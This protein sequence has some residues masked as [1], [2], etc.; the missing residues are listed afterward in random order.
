M[1]G[2]QRI[3][4]MPTNYKTYTYVYILYT[5]R[6][7]SYVQNNKMHFPKCTS[8]RLVGTVSHHF[9]IISANDFFFNSLKHIDY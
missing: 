7:S 2:Y 1:N 9:C 6:R 8:A 3:I 5:H 4:I